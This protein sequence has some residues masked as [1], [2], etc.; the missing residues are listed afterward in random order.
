MKTFEI[1]EEFK[2]IYELAEEIEKDENGEIVDNSDQLSEL[3]AGVEVELSA[4]L[5]NTN[6]VIKELASAEQ[7][8]KDEAKRLTEKARVFKNKQDYL[9]SLMKMAIESSGQSK[10]KT[11]KFSFSVSNRKDFDY[12]DVSLFGL[13]PNLIRVKEELNKTAIKTF[14]K[15]G[16]VVDGLVEIKKSSLTIR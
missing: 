6:Y 10:I 13:D 16:G 5:D 15:A 14:V 9:K 3:F 2:A 1:I 8:L 11:D 7:C 4:K 12:T